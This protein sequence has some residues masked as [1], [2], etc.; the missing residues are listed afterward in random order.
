MSKGSFSTGQHFGVLSCQEIKAL[1]LVIEKE[2]SYSFIR[3]YF[4]EFVAGV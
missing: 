4:L 1:L 3:Q 2:A